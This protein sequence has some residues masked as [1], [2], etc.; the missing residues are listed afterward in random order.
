M[1]MRP[2]DR[3]IKLNVGSMS[4]T[5]D[6]QATFAESNTNFIEGI[7]QR[8]ASELRASIWRFL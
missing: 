3:T 4:G 6:G 1:R 8:I 7:F 5:D 2:E